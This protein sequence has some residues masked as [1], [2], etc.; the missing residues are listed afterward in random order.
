M[1]F[2]KFG[3]GRAMASKKQ[4]R[5]AWEKRILSW[6]ASG[7]T[8]TAWCQE[9]DVYRAAFYHWKK[10]FSEEVLSSDSFVEIEEEQIKEEKRVGIEIEYKGLRVHLSKNFDSK[11]LLRCI[12]ILKS[13]PC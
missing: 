3:D 8:V 4:T 7:K 5:A 12:E 6:K 9:H 1:F 13:L 2:S 10:Q 11:T